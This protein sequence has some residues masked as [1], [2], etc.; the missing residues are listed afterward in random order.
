[1]SP[2]QARRDLA[3]HL[4]EHRHQE[5]RPD[6]GGVRN[7][8]DADRQALRGDHRQRRPHGGSR[9]RPP[10]AGDRA[11]RG[12]PPAR[13]REGRQR[14]RPV[15][16]RRPALADRR[17]QLRL[18]GPRVDHER[19]RHQPG[20][21]AGRPRGRRARLP[22]RVEESRT[23]ALGGAQAVAGRRARVHVHEAEAKRHDRRLVP[24]GARLRHGQDRVSPAGGDR[25]RVQQQL[26]AGHPLPQ[27][28]RLR[29]RARRPDAGSGTRRPN[30]APSAPGARRRA[31]RQARRRPAQRP[32]PCRSRSPSALP[33][34][35]PR[36]AARAGRRARRPS[37]ARRRVP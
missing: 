24:D 26:R 10:A 31:R 14:H 29:R 32:G 20:G 37:R 1:M 21:G 18:H 17:E 2:G 12:L 34:R 27:R 6:P 23:S 36:L 15:V 7:H 22:L 33:A 9:L 5:A 19:R 4:P 13:V 11:P 3:A 8:P 35:P 16:D 25:V 28:D 30:S